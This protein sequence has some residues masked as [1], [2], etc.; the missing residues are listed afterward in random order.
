MRS[1]AIFPPPII[2]Q[3]TKKIV[4]G[5]HRVKAWIAEYGLD[6]EIEVEERAYKNRKEILTDF[7]KENLTHGRPLS[8]NEKRQITIELLKENMTP[9]A[10]SQLFNVPVKAIKNYAGMSVMVLEGKKEETRAIKKGIEHLAGTTMDK[11]KYEEHRSYDRGISCTAQVNQLIRW[12]DNGWIEH[13]QKNIEL[14][15]KLSDCIDG[16]LLNEDGKKVG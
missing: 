4:S 6:H 9:E 2:D 12:I 7:A 10:C 3:K 13:N 5:N 15:A 11:D 1:G 14:F 16:F 8:G